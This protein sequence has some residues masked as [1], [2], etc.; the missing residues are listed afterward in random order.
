MSEKN[1]F[2]TKFYFTNCLIYLK[3]LETMKNIFILLFLLVPYILQAQFGN[4]QSVNQIPGKIHRDKIIGWKE[5][6]N[7]RSLH[8]SSYVKPDGTQVVY[9]SKEAV[10]YLDVNNQWL[11]VSTL[12]NVD[13]NGWHAIYQKNP[14]SV[15]K[16]GSV[17]TG[18]FIFSQTNELN[19][20]VANFDISNPLLVKDTLSFVNYSPNINKYFQFRNNG[21][22]YSYVLNQE[23]SMIGDFIIKEKIKLKS[24]EYKIFLN[25]KNSE[26][27]GFIEIR[28]L[29]GKVE[30]SI[31]PLWCYDGSGKTITGNYRIEKISETEFNLIM[32]VPQYYFEQ[33]GLTYPVVLDPLITGPTTTWNGGTMPSCFA[34]NVNQDSILITVPAQISVNGLLVTSNYYANPFTTTVMADGHM[35]FSTSCATSTDF[36]VAPPIGNSPGTG[37]LED[38]NLRSPLMCCFP[39][40]CNSYA[41]YL[42]M[43]L[44]RTSNGNTCNTTYLY[45]DPTSI[46]PFSAYIEGNTV[47]NYNSQA[48]VSANPICSNQCTFQLTTYTRYGVPPFTLTHPWLATPYTT[49]IAAGC[50][51]SSTPQNVLLTIPNCPVYCD[52]STTLLVPPPT[53]TDACGNTVSS[54]PTLSLNIKP[55][56]N[57]SALEDTVIVCSNEVAVLNLVP[58]IPGA[59]IIWSGHNASGTGSIILDSLT[60][61]LSSNYDSYIYSAYSNLNN[62]IGDTSYF[63]IISEPILS[64]DFNTSPNPVFIL[65]PVSFADITNTVSEIIS[66]SWTIDNLPFS[67]DSI[68][69]FIFSEP[70]D[71]LVCLEIT[72]STGCL[73]T[74]CKIITVLPLEIVLPNI[75]TPNGDALNEYLSFEYLTFF[76]S[77]SLSVFNR[78]GSL[79]FEKNNY[80]N[81]WNGGENTEGVYFFVLTV[82]EKSYSGYFHLI[83]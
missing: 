13:Q 83:R 30:Y 60:E 10:N 55:V 71:Y 64:A 31:A 69:N 45:Y 48:I 61:N 24:N 22:K 72:T 16:D 62:C 44:N 50:S 5:N 79:I 66:W 8:S 53:V 1:N 80:Q 7:E 59:N 19:G 17:S 21:I 41:F 4:V 68:S 29:E 58:C 37:Y 73:D 63:L 33:R 23:V 75:I 77:N 25:E 20:T 36:T 32:S 12:P 81:D 78:W 70:G 18:G 51:S 56:S 57:V 76:E 43:N 26:R 34:P 46:W 39:Q 15:L 42:T 3:E 28:N 40:Q 38:F 27:P 11:P 74:I 65:D 47:E 49:G 67:N 2:R 54:W 82:E 52:T 6:I 35:T 9:F 14:F